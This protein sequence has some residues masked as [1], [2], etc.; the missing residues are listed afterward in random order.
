VE[1][2][3]QADSWSYQP[4]RLHKWIGQV[5]NNQDELRHGLIR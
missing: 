5:K 3:G 4:Q 2:A 1:H